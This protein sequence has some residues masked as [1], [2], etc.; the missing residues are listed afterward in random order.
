LQSHDFANPQAEAP[1]DE[2]HGAERFA[3]VRQSE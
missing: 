1:S 3:N 2:H